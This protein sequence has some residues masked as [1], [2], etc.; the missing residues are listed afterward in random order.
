[1]KY[2][3]PDFILIEETEFRLAIINPRTIQT[4][5]INQSIDSPTKQS[6]N[7]STHQS[8]NQSINR[9]SNKAINQSINP[10]INQ[11]INQSIDSPTDQSIEWWSFFRS[12]G[13][14]FQKFGNRIL[15][16]G[17]INR[18]SVTCTLH[19]SYQRQRLIPECG[20]RTALL[21]LRRFA[22][23]FYRGRGL[24][25]LP[26][27]TGFFRQ[28]PARSAVIWERSFCATS[29]GSGSGNSS[30]SDRRSGRFIISRRVSSLIL[31]GLLYLIVFNHRTSG[32]CF[33]NLIRRRWLSRFEG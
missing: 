23:H 18:S 16:H 26:R 24:A 11:S 3:S 8:T 15:L 29:N 2:S 31:L 33:L 22:S 17:K 27:L 19:F 25:T 7:R 9:Q 32:R 4:N 13:L 20:V 6:I 30:D 10:S 28:I 5:P 1:M 14:V 21:R 12:L